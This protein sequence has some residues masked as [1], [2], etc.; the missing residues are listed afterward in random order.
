VRDGD[1]RRHDLR[2]ETLHYEE[3]GAVLTATGGVLATL[4]ARGADD[5][6]A[7]RPSK[8][9][10][11]AIQVTGGS[12][13]A[14]LAPAKAGPG[15]P[16]AKDGI[17]GQLRR[18]T[19]DDRVVVDATLN[20]MTGDRLVYDVATGIGELTGRP[21][22][23]VSKMESEVYTSWVNADLIRAYFATT[24]DEKTKGQ[25]LR[26]T[27]PGGGRM[28]R[29]L[30]PPNPDTGRAEGGKDPQRIQLVSQGPI[31][32]T[33]TD[34]TATGNVIATV[35]TLDPRGEWREAARMDCERA[36]MTFDAD[37]TGTAR[38]KIRTFDAEGTADVPV[39][40]TTPDFRA[41]CSRVD[42]DAKTTLIRL[43]GGERPVWFVEIATGRQFF[44]DSGTFDYIKREWT[45]QERAREVEPK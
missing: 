12:M 29:Y 22:R 19:M 35:E 39:S 15:S 40:V 36:H 23:V 5:K 9:V 30:D 2:A 37:A 10:E 33:R 20:R 25:L 21:A 3:S 45:E 17:D 24:G 28:V 16:A 44:E 7:A 34:A 38:E 13:R 1:G 41:T 11:G 32:V 4:D 6:K 27:C 43:T 18:L 26:A 14:E 31:D 8:Y 42:I